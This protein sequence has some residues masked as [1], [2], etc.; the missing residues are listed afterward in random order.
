[1][2]PY[3]TLFLTN[4]PLQLTLINDRLLTGTCSFT[5]LSLTLGAIPAWSYCYFFSNLK[6]TR[7]MLPD[8][9]E[10]KFSWWQ[11]NNE[12]T[13]PAPVGP[14]LAGSPSPSP[15][16]QP[17]LPGLTGAAHA[18]LACYYCLSP[19]SI[20]RITV[21][22]IYMHGVITSGHQPSARFATPFVLCCAANNRWLWQQWL[23][24]S[25]VVG[26]GYCILWCV[27]KKKKFLR[28]H[29]HLLPLGLIVVLFWHP[30]HSSARHQMLI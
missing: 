15:W 16:Q 1:M 18:G 27:E 17:F 13:P 7:N 2:W 12:T 26:G 3:G 22:L 4:F 9:C 23:A 29:P 6:Q 30:A 10:T 19:L 28:P 21:M 5:S 14:R 11:I 20:T 24:L 25:G 8:C